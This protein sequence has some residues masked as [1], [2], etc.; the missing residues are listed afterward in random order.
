MSSDDFE[1]HEQDTAIERIWTIVYS[2]M[3]TNLMLFF[4]MLYGLSRMSG[5][6]RSEIM[7]N[8]Q[9]KFRGKAD[10]EARAQ[11]VLKNIKE[12][13]AAAKVSS[14]MQKQGLNEYTSVEINE[15]QIKIT[16][17]IPVLFGSG[18]AVLGDK[19]KSVLASVS[20]VIAAVPNQVIIEGHTDNQTVSRGRYGSNWELSVARAY[21]VVDYFVRERKIDPA[22]F[23]V[24]G[25]GEFKPV[26]PNTTP[27]GRSANRRIEILMVR[28]SAKL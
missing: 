9:E 15:K 6:A 14:M 17:N 5:D 21:S 18:E 4:L 8:M 28:K 19:A 25:Y 26:A 20:K 3:I 11:K 16:L 10:V 12:E 22:R 24:A 27:E 13:D 7:Q 2:D 1:Q 23:V